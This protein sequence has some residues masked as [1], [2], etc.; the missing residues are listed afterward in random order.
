[1]NT[2]ITD[3]VDN[4]CKTKTVEMAKSSSDIEELPV[5]LEAADFKVLYSLSPE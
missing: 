2:I 4:F 5:D 1:M 3:A